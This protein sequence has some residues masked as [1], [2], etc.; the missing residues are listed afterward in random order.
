M[1]NNFFNPN[2]YRTPIVTRGYPMASP[3]P[4]LS[5][6]FR[7]APQTIRTAPGVSKVT[8]SSILNGASKTL[9]VI[10]QAIPVIYQVKPIWRNAKTMF[11]VAKELN[12]NSNTS[13]NKNVVNS[14]NKQSIK[15]ESSNN[16]PTFFI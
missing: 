14:T 8:F 15:K 2:M 6:F 13:S 1:N 7:G 12:S 9:G 11:R 16:S 5:S 10:N 3:F 4:R